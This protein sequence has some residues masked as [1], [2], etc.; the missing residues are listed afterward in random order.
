MKSLQPLSHCWRGASRTATDKVESRRTLVIMTVPHYEE[1]EIDGA[2]PNG[3]VDLVMK[4]DIPR[5]LECAE[6]SGYEFQ[7]GCNEL[8]RIVPADMAP[9]ITFGPPRRPGT[10]ISLPVF[11][12][13]RGESCPS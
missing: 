2:G 6:K 11:W 10:Q 5:N 13:S 9:L 7:D 4:P 1:F 12:S 3:D 8:L